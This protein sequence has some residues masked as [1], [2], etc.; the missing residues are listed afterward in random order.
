MKQFTC[1]DMP[2]VDTDDF[3]RVSDTAIP[4]RK[5]CILFM[6]VSKTVRERES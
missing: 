2:E 5:H 6:R 4:I 3:N 1:I